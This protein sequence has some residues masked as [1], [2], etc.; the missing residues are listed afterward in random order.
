MNKAV[1]SE[2]ICVGLKK[3][4]QKHNVFFLII[5]L[6][7]ALENA[8]YMSIAGLYIILIMDCVFFSKIDLILCIFIFSSLKLI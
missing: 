6:L 7:R 4:R 3:G 8:I 2:Y 5:I 1:L